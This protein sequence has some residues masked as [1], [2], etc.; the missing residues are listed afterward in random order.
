MRIPAQNS[1]QS[2][3]LIRL[4]SRILAVGGGG[5]YLWVNCSTTAFFWG[6]CFDVPPGGRRRCRPPAYVRHG[7]R[8]PCMSRR[9]AGEGWAR[10]KVGGACPDRPGTP[11]RTRRVRGACARRTVPPAGY[12]AFFFE[13]GPALRADRIFPPAGRPESRGCRAASGK[14]PLHRIRFEPRRPRRVRATGC[15]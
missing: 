14:R 1:S 8:M 12:A 6:W 5:G 11:M 4:R 2:G 9:F 7:R 15:G 3:I 13:C 10:K